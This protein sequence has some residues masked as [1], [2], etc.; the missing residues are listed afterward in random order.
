MKKVT[1]L[2]NFQVLGSSSLLGASWDSISEL[3]TN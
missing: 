1:L 3:Y 2:W